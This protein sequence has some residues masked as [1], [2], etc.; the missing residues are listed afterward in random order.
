MFRKYGF[1]LLIAIFLLNIILFA[2]GI[3][4]SSP[5]GKIDTNTEVDIKSVCN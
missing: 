4:E 3:P 2:R 5:E 1:S